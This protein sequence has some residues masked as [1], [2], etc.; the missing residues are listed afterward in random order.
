MNL[1]LRQVRVLDPLSHCDR[2]ADVW[3]K[4]GKIKAIEKQIAD[5]APE[6][7]IKNSENLILAPGLTD[8]YSTNNDPGREERETVASLS[9]AA[10][11]GGFTRLTLLPHIAPPLDNPAGLTLLQRKVPKGAPHLQFWGALTQNLEGEQMVELAE[12]ADAGVV[13]FSDGKAIAHWGVLRRLLEYARP[14]GK[15]IAIV[16]TNL[17]LRDNGVMREGTLS[18]PLGLPGDPAF[19]ETAALAALLEI[20]AIVK[21]PVHVM[22]VSTGRGVELIAEAKRRELPVTASVT[23]LHL[24]L[25]TE[26]VGSYD[27]SLHLDPPLGNPSDRAALA[28]GVK[29]GIIDAIAIDHSPYTY[30]E[31]TVSFAEAPPGAIGFELALPLLWENLVV[32]GDWTGLQL[33]RA[34]SVSP[35][36]CLGQ[37]PLACVAGE[38]VESVLFDPQKTWIVNSETLFSQ[39]TNTSWWGEEIRGK[40]VSVIF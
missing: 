24:L 11:A 34:L 20:V 30:E 12:L 5:I 40:I 21:T 18:I 27:P 37:K 25:D 33:W 3:L 2:I 35:Q 22:R 14:L 7:T 38:T 32:K 1:L 28:D 19:S 31:K 29:S 4:D 13:G 39:S 10:L 17:Q 26:A 23:W 36:M 16:P 9:K 6:T 8:L 15:P